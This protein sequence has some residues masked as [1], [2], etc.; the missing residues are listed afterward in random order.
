MEPNQQLRA[1]VR[2]FYAFLGAVALLGIGPVIAMN[3]IEGGGQ[4]ARIAGVAIAM[5]AWIPWIVVVIGM[6]RRGD[7]FALRVHLVGLAIAFFGLMTVLAAL[8]WLARAEFIATPDLA[9]VWPVGLVLWFAG[10]LTANHWYQ[11]SP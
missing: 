10:I 1:N 9:F 8:D 4:R 7:E 2:T 11:R 5:A 6:I 3:L